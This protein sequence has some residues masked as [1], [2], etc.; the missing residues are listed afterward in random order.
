MKAGN[1][2]GLAYLRVVEAA[3]AKVVSPGRRTRRPVRALSA[4]RRHKLT[5][6]G[7]VLP[8]LIVAIYHLTLAAPVFVS[9][10][11]F[12]V[13]LSSAPTQSP[14]GTIL[15]SS[16]I[17]RS[18]DDSFSVTDFL[19]SRDALRKLDEAQPQRDVFAKPVMDVVARFPLLWDN[20]SFEG[21]YRYFRSKVEVVNNSSTEVVTLRTRAFAAED[22]FN[23]NSR[24]LV[25]ASGLLVRMNN[26]AREDAITFSNWEVANA[27]QRLLNIQADITTFRNEQLIVDPTRTS[28]VM[29]DTIGRLSTELALTRAKR[30][31]TESVAPGSV[32]MVGLN[33][34]IVALEDQID[35]ERAK[36][37]GGGMSV[38]SHIAK[39]EQLTLS[40]ELA[41]KALAAA[42]TSLE[43]ARADAQRRQLY[44]E[45][46]V[47]PNFPDEAIEPQSGT[48][49]AVTFLLGAVAC[50]MGWVLWTA[51]SEHSQNRKLRLRFEARADQ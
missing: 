39:Y 50:L 11:K 17:V 48:R 40:R 36:L 16:G 4:F 22:A 45:P 38:S 27:E 8:T 15:Q 10:S 47:Q 1:A 23:M 31:E 5:I 29:L 3:E 35:L 34:R 51:V 41:S 25:A 7:V 6:L 20:S 46:I 2:S 18:Q 21:L 13:R 44:L 32:A 24:L 9:E 14:I 28:V 30:F 19:T 42:T 33:N 49:I 26:R 43:T 37:V 12:V